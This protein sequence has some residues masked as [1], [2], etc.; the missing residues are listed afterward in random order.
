MSSDAVRMVDQ[1]APVPRGG[2][3]PVLLNARRGRTGTTP[4]AVCSR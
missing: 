4:W 2:W 1:D 3:W